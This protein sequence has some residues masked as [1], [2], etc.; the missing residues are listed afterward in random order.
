[1]WCVHRRAVWNRRVGALTARYRAEEDKS[2]RLV[3]LFL[4][5]QS[6]FLQH[7]RFLGIG[8]GNLNTVWNWF[9]IPAFVKTKQSTGTI[10]HVIAVKRCM[11]PTVR[12]NKWK[13]RLA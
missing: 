3:K 7:I 5:S 6:Q 11:Q 8:V 4:D 10:A 2:F 1:M 13:M 9:R 12:D